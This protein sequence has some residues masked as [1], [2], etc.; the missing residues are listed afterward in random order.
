MALI[1]DIVSLETVI[2]VIVVDDGV[3][4]KNSDDGVLS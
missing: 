4:V 3:I 1:V 2:G